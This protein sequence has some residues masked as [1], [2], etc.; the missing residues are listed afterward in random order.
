MLN[1]PSISK[2]KHSQLQFT[3]Q[4]IYQHLFLSTMTVDQE[5]AHSTQTFSHPNTIHLTAHGRTV[6][7]TLHTLRNSDPSVRYTFMVVPNQSTSWTHARRKFT[8]LVTSVI[9]FIVCG[10]QIPTLSM[11]QAMSHLTNTFNLQFN[12]PRQKKQAG[13]Q[14]PHT[15]S[16]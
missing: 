8:S 11:L 12:S 1:Y 15:N 9:I 7:R 4:T 16:L 5:E 10:I 13:Q 6:P 3:S 2:T 14:T